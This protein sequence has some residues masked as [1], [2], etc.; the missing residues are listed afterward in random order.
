M[1]DTL[2]Y[3]WK[4]SIIKALKIAGNDLHPHNKLEVNEFGEICGCAKSLYSDIIKVELIFLLY[5]LTKISLSL[6]LGLYSLPSHQV[7]VLASIFPS[8]II[9]MHRFPCCSTPFHQQG[10]YNCDNS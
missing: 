1:K 10:E 4:Q 9:V 5:K 3:G 2:E 7:H 6:M 8:A